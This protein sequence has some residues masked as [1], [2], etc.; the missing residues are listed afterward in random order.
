MVRPLFRSFFGFLLLLSLASPA[1]AQ[2]AGW[3][4][5]ADRQERIGENHIRLSGNVTL[6]HGDTEL[7][8]DVVEAFTD[9]NR[10]IASGNVVLTQGPNRISADRADFDTKT[11]LGTFYNASGIATYQPPRQAPPAGGY[12]APQ[13]VGQ[14]N[15]VYF[16]GDTIE[17]IGQQKYRIS[18]GGFTTC[19]Q[20]TPRWDLHGGTVVLNIDHYTML[21]D[22]VLK[23]KG[24]PMLYVPIM[25]YPTKRD[26]RATGLLIPTYGSSSLR[27][28]SLHNA[29]FWAIDRSQDATFMHDWY[30]KTGQGVGSEYRYNFGGGSD[31][32]VRAYWLN[33]HEATYTQS[34]GSVSTLPAQ[35]SYEIRGNANQQLP[36][37]LRARGRVDYFSSLTTMQ[38]FN[39]NIYDASRNQRSFGGNVVGAWGS[40][41]LNATYDRTQYFY[42][43]TNS[44]TTGSAPRISVS[45][46]ERPLVG[47]LYFTINGE[48]AS[49]LYESQGLGPA[50][51]LIDDNRGLTRLDVTP[52]IR[53]P[54]KKWQ[55]F[56]VNTS[57]GWRDTYYTRSLD[58]N[59]IDPQTSRPVVVEDNL[60]RRYYTLQAQIVGPV[61]NRIWDT[62]GNGYAEKFK[63]TIEPFLNVARTSPIDNYN[64]IVVIDATDSIVGGTTYTYGLNNRFYAKRRLQ[65]GRPAQSREIVDVTL[66]QS[67]YTNQFASQIDQ[68]YVTSY[69][70]APPSHFSPYALAVRGVPTDNLNV[71]VRAEFDSRYRKLRTISATG[72]YNWSGLIQTS[73]GWSKQGYIA[74]L[75]GYNNPE[76]LPQAVTAAVNAHTRDNRFGS[77]YSFNY[78]VL[79]K[80]ML[81]QQISGFYNAQCCGIAFQYQTFNFAGLGAA[82]PIPADRRFFLSFTLAGL[83]SFSPFSGAMNNVPH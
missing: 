1:A 71:M 81:Q 60:N 25:Y 17:K 47:D 13:L 37:G 46:N 70:G 59:T 15:D 61:F 2:I 21:R 74:Q 36:F 27:G 45:R 52:Q 30:S 82:V 41:S 26:G 64:Q 48:F 5:A 7:F 35:R 18:H 63:H 24:V 80:A 51:T 8:A 34:D 69:S 19:V 16:F 54:F 56:T 22:A 43:D 66:T 55:W 31:G 6:R 3:T 83:G 67:Y 50:G 12:Q 20:P 77:V 10:L 28:Q 11:Q 44:S 78:D 23:V 33:D 73:A 65:E 49:L 9:E 39:T 75:P 32:D 40:Y 76:T 62:P 57:F 42:N 58:P 4:W 72:T 14:E 38:T 79:H 29:F 68:Q 53:Y